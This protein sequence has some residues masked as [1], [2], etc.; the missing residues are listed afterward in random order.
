MFSNINNILIESNV[1][2]NIKKNVLDHTTSL[3]SSI[4]HK[5]DDFY[6]SINDS[7]SNILISSHKSFIDHEKD[8][9]STFTSNTK[10]RNT[11][12]EVAYKIIKD[13]Y[14]IYQSGLSKWTNNV[15]I[16]LSKFILENNKDTDKQVDIILEAIKKHNIIAS[17][18]YDVLDDIR[19][20]T[21]FLPTKE[22]FV[23]NILYKNSLEDTYFYDEDSVKSC[24]KD[25]DHL[26]TYF[27]SGTY[28]AKDIIDSY[29]NFKKDIKTYHHNIKSKLASLK[30]ILINQSKQLKEDYDR[31]I[32]NKDISDKDKLSYIE[33]YKSRCRRN[34]HLMNMLNVSYKYQI[35]L[36]LDS[37]RIYVETIQKI[38]DDLIFSNKY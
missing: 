33:E 21:V 24:M 11:Q 26:E 9:F 15:D 28:D 19:F 31:I 5:I 34:L 37:L 30:Q 20:E 1:T 22:Y 35:R 12:A 13:K 7:L 8:I 32:Y 36:Y 6:S 38:Y 27:S 14:S 16:K 10:E 29:N 23:D 4:V 17:R 25:R 3:I 18:S 2:T